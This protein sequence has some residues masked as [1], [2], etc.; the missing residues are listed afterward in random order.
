VDVEEAYVGLVGLE[1]LDGFAA[2]A[3][4]SYDVQLGPR[5][6]ELGRE[7]FAQQRFVLGDQG[8]RAARHRSRL[9]RGEIDL[10]ARA[11]TGRARRGGRRRR[12]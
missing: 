10:S 11:A 6:R 4:L 12:R 8:G 3:R 9:H 5:V 7:G 2:V 1:L